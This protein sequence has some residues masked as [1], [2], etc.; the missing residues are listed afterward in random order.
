MYELTYL[1]KALGVVVDGLKL[2]VLELK[3]NG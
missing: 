2:Q 3:L 1:V